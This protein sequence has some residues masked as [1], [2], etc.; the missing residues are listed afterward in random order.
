MSAY[1]FEVRIEVNGPVLSQATGSRDLGLDAAALRT[2][3]N[4]PALP[5]NLI[6][7]NLH[8]AWARFRDMAT[9]AGRNGD[10][11][12]P[13]H[14][15]GQ[16]SP[17][18][19]GDAPRR[20][21][22]RFS[23]YWLA[24]T[25]AAQDAVRHRIAIAPETGAVAPMA[26]QVI[27]SPF[28][29][30]AEPAF[31]GTIEADLPDQTAADDLAERIRKGLEYAGSLGALKGVGFGRVKGVMV[32]VALIPAAPPAGTGLAGCTRIGFRLRPDRPFCVA[33]PHAK[34]N[35]F[36]SE[37]LIPGGVIRGAMAARLFTGDRETDCADGRFTRLCEHFG[38]VL[39]SHALP[40]R[41]A[42]GGRP[43]RPVIPPFSLV[44]APERAHRD[45][46]ALYDVARVSEA[47][48]LIYDRAPAFCP[49]WKD[50][51]L[52]LVACGQSADL[53]RLIAVRTAIDATTQAAAETALFATEAVVPDGHEWI[54]T[55]DLHEVPNA[56]RAAVVDQ[57]AL[58][59]AAPLTQIGKTKASAAVTLDPQP[60]D[61]TLTEGDPGG[62]LLRDGVACVCLQSDALLLPNPWGIPGTG[63]ASVLRDRYAETWHRL[64]QGRLALDGNRYFARQVLV[65]GDF[66]HHRF[67]RPGQ[68]YNPAL[69]TIAGS[70]F[71]LRPTD[72]SAEGLAA[73]ESV[74]DRWRRAGLD[75][76]STAD[77][78]AA[79]LAARGDWRHN[80][81]IRQNGYGA[82]AVNL[83]LHWTLAPLPEAWHGID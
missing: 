82:V 13:G 46:N 43:V 5:G 3:A 39:V 24:E 36:E 30:G 22:L 53:R 58:L 31:V 56:D 25:A 20:A 51:A 54:G 50:A 59:F 45:R 80:P 55:I 67:R 75:Q 47:A 60:F 72:D 74:L 73:A 76:V 23:H 81:Y 34:N 16:P 2:E 64:S 11:W 38:Q 40:V 6:R 41:E 17:A 33:R 37:D 14:W 57:L 18:K 28:G 10:A 66:L 63:G 29:P 27:D 21:R 70:V 4:T 12:D 68:P 15:L 7:G 49:D 8:H 26:L 79:A 71:L 9:A 69:L 83:D 65:G 61:L 48:G 1:R 44:E 32:K 42:G 78:D 35:L 62:G 52:A 77:E 19:S